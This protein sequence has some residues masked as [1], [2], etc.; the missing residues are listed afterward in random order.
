MSKTETK[1]R[2]LIQKGS[3]Q[4]RNHSEKGSVPSGPQEQ[5]EPET[6]GVRDSFQETGSEKEV[7]TSIVEIRTEEITGSFTKKNT[8][9]GGNGFRVKCSRRGGVGSAQEKTSKRE[10]KFPVSSGP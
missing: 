10:K 8:C 2:T 4:K 3:S 9:Q 5:G 7:S 6:I 1:S